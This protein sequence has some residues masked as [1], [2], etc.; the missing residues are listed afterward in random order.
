M[1]YKSHSA[2]SLQATKRECVAMSLM[3][4]KWKQMRMVGRAVP[5]CVKQEEVENT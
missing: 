3:Q 1:G 5:K 4:L 2:A